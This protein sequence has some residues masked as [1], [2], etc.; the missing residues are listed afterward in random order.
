MPR[1]AQA[2]DGVGGVKK[3][4]VS[5][6]EK[7]GTEDAKWPETFSGKGRCLDIPIWPILLLC[8]LCLQVSLWLSD[9]KL[10]GSSSRRRRDSDFH[11]R[12][13][14][15]PSSVP[16]DC[17]GFVAPAF[18]SIAWSSRNLIANLPLG[19]LRQ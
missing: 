14:R 10:V 19:R 1:L 6:N 4:E 17:E 11:K 5:R 15:R 18:A 9:L 8:G 13:A 16:C 2:S 3:R 7:S 12:C